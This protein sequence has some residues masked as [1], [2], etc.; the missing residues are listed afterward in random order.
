MPS[1]NYKK[2]CMELLESN[3]EEQVVKILK[4]WGFWDNEGAWQLYGGIENN[5]SV[6]G[7]QQ[8]SAQAAL[9][10][11][12]VNSI[13][14]VLMRECYRRGINPE[15]DSAPKSME[16]ALEAFFGLKTNDLTLL[17]SKERQKLARNIGFIATGS[18]ER[19][20]LIVLDRGEGQSPKYFPDTLLSLNRSN[21]M[22]IFFVQGK[23]NMGGTGALTFC[24]DEHN[25]QLIISRRHPDA[26][27]YDEHDPR[28]DE[29][30][31]TIVRRRKP[32]K[33]HRSSIYQYLAP[34]GQVLS[35]TSKTLDV[36]L[37]YSSIDPLEWGTLIKLY[38]YDLGNLK[39][40]IKQ[41]FF[42]YGASLRLP[43]PALPIMFYEDRNYKSDSPTLTYHGLYGRLASTEEKGNIEDGFPVY[44][45]AKVR[46]QPIMIEIYAFRK[47][48]EGKRQPYKNFIRPS[49]AIIFT[50]NGQTH[51]TLSNGFFRR[52]RV[53][54]D[55]IADSL[56]VIV[57]CDQLDSET[58]EDFFMNSRDRL[59]QRN[60]E[61]L[62]SVLEEE[63]ARHEALKE[64]RERRRREAL[65][66][67]LGNDQPL[68]DLLN[69]ILKNSPTLAK[70]FIE[71]QRISNPFDTRPA[72]E[73]QKR[74]EG[75]RFPTYFL[76]REK[77][78][79][80]NYPIG[81]TIRIQFETDAVNDFFSRSEDRGTYSL[82]IYNDEGECIPYPEG[83]KSFKL[84]NGTATLVLQLPDD[85]I[86]VG[87]E[88]QCCLL[89]ESPDRIDPFEN[90][91]T[92]TVVPH[93]DHST[94]EAGKRKPPTEEGGGKREQ[95]Q[96]LAT[97]EVILIRESEW[98]EH[99]F[100]KESA[101]SIQP[102]GESY[103]FYINIDNVY[104]QTEI[105]ANTK[106]DRQVLE[107]QFQNALVLFGLSIV[108]LYEANNT[109]NGQNSETTEIFQNYENIDGLAR[110]LSCAI[111]PVLLPMINSLGNLELVESA[112]VTDD[113]DVE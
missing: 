54:M 43:Q 5:F 105:K 22:R 71:G 113:Q 23:F 110:P 83:I 28:G 20:S 49:E 80:R 96:R 104:L 16:E 25:L 34:A 81:N 59:R 82:C 107:M 108:R 58:R 21:K 89:V 60:L 2:L 75:K 26:R 47:N 51:A 9:I 7:N 64:L 67:K 55:Y 15:S 33:N 65:S 37:E 29:W 109:G 94:G 46:R 72:S 39:T 97:P 41:D 103:D 27:R 93:I 52:K 48:F 45:E 73:S 4:R 85:E 50:I 84:Y 66:K 98:E 17:S 18:K 87:D 70:I 32:S 38:E 42:Y 77:H 68:V 24:S 56:L 63:I 30:G 111:A 91:F 31:F 8:S 6:I 35:F 44:I 74:F 40:N 3:S 76:I 99:N 92:V 57:K 112:I 62:E 78:E 13:D 12:F 10:E 95:E 88:Y 101:L 106:I 53:K 102:N 100:N 61:E 11:K 79:K 1:A 14:A 69:K 90:K 36:P 86:Q 19:P